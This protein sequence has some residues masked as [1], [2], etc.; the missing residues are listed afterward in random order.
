[1]ICQDRLDPTNKLHGG[2]KC[3]TKTHH[4]IEEELK[5]GTESTREN[6][7][8]MLREAYFSIRGAL[9]LKSFKHYIQ[10]LQN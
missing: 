10:P 3:E 8:A 9:L 2:I 7:D 5:T 6:H 1:V 4:A